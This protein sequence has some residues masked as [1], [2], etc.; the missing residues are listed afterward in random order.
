MTSLPTVTATA[1]VTVPE[2][3]V[4]QASSWRKAHESGFAPAG[5]FILLALLVGLYDNSFFRMPSLMS[6][7]EQS[8]PLVL[9]A[10]AQGIV[11]LV[12]RIT[13]ANATLASLAGIALAQILGSLGGIAVPVVLL[14]TALL[15]VIMGVVH[16]ITQTPSFIVSLGFMGVFAGL[17]LW[18]SGADSVLVTDGFE[19]IE[20]LSLRLYGVPISFV[21]VLLVTAVLMLAMKFLPFGRRVQAI[22][23]N[24][25]AAAFSGIRTTRIVVGVFALSGLLSGLAAV[26]QVSQLQSA[27]ATTSDSLLLPSIAAVLVGGCSIAGGVGGIG[28]MLLGAMVIALLRVGLDLVGIDSA[29]QPIFY[30]VIVILAIAATVDRKRGSTVA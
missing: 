23:H 12:G 10:M 7:L 5:I 19:N 25:R 1:P 20:W 3:K 29:Y 9:L 22:G 15:G 11:V 26:M 4:P 17:A 2:T 16:V 28:R 30:G 8:V 27:G 24:E 18:L 13:L 6:L 21:V 14:V